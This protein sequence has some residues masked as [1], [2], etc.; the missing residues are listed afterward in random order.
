MN[1]ITKK[2][3]TYKSNSWN[4]GLCKTASKQKTS[5]NQNMQN[6]SQ[7]YSMIMKTPEAT[8]ATA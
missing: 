7:V 4:R 6:K 1:N 5:L 2:G 8:A 3:Q